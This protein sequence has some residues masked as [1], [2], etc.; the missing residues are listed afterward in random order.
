MPRRTQRGWWIVPDG[1]GDPPWSLAVPEGELR[2]G[3]GESC[4]LRL[5]GRALSTHHVTF[6]RKGDELSFRDEGSTAGSFLNDTVSVGDRLAP[7]DRLRL[8]GVSLR[9]L[10][11][12]PDLATREE[13]AS[14]PSTTVAESPSSWRGFP[15]FLELLRRSEEPKEILEG[16]LHG[17]VGAAAAERGVVMLVEGD[18][19]RLRPVAFHAVE[20][21]DPLVALSGTIA[22]TAMEEGGVLFIDDT[23]RHAVSARA[24]SALAYRV[25]RSVICKALSRGNEVF[26][27]VYVDMPMR[28]GGLDE[29]TRLLFT[30]VADLA[31]EVLS[32]GRTRARLLAAEGK[33][34]AMAR[35]AGQAPPMIHGR[36]PASRRLAADIEAAA[37]HDVTVLLLGQT[38]TGKELA[39]LE[40]HGASS[41][42]GG[43]FV[44]VNC[45]ALPSELAEAEL[46]GAVAGAYT[47]ATRDRPGRFEWADGGTLFLDEIAEMPMDLQVKMLRVLQERRI[48]PLGAVE[49]IPVD[50]RLI[51]ATHVDLEAAVREGRFREDLYYRI[52]VLPLRIPSLREREADVVLFARAFLDDAVRR[53]GKGGCRFSSE[54]EALLAEHDWPG[55]LRELRNVV[56]RAV[57]R[58]ATGRIEGE[59]LAVA[60]SADG[61]S[62]RARSVADGE[63]EL[64]YERAMERFERDFLAAAL[65]RADGGVSA[66]ARALGMSRF[67]LHRRMNRLGLG[68]RSR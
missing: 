43:P 32:A 41:R 37:A 56:E 4:H 49:S 63:E 29:E 66:A 15:R 59:D 44:A 3:A 16:L 58:C 23:S 27:V 51:C 14:V 38:G 64:D 34:L 50:L 67:A 60:P 9:V 61:P 46:F 33:I 6:V 21:A 13:G 11:E 18:E 40:I 8:G 68:K 22:K 26:G 48:T 1:D 7:G 53:Y 5:A 65:D 2:V 57:V 24:E 20:R 52:N 55:N 17:L 12:A 62:G 28:S 36:S 47:G 54:A 35:G 19:A 10:D 45:G 42:A 39:A 30:S 31:A 25:P